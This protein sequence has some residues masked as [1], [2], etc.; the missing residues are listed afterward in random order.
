MVNVIDAA[1]V[2]LISNEDVG[3]IGAAS[4]SLSL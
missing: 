3:L 1:N 4:L 2:G